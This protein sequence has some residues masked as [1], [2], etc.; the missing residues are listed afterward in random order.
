MPDFPIRITG[1]A[2]KLAQAAAEA[3]RWT[4][5]VEQMCPAAASFLMCHRIDIYFF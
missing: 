5:P 3:K 2:S 1:D 4:W